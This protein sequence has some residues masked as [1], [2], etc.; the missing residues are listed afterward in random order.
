MDIM[1][2]M[3]NAKPDPSIFSLFEACTRRFSDLEKAIS[4]A[5][6]L[7]EFTSTEFYNERERFNIWTNSSGASLIGGASLDF[8]LREATDLRLRVLDR[9]T[10]LNVSLAQ[11]MIVEADE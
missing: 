10:R 6:E 9:L 11:G 7:N 1:D 8:R 2:F 4:S 3:T 5:Q